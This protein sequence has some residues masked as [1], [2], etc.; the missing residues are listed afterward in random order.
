MHPA[1]RHLLDQFHFDHLRTDHLRR[2]SQQF[3]DLAHDLAEVLNDGPELSAGL[4]KLL[5][6]KDCCVRQAVMD[7]QPKES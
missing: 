2:V 6:A 4:R 3:H 1:T 5:E 7:A